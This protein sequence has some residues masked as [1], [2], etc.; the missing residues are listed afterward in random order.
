MLDREHWLSAGT[1]FEMGVLVE[2]RRIF[3]PITLDK[4]DNVGVYAPKDKLRMSGLVW[5]EAQAA[6]AQKAY[7]IHQSSGAGHVIA[8]AEEPN[9]RAYTEGT[10]LLFANAVLLGPAF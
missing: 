1:D 2:S 10:M 3:T 9:Y 5:D 6:L 4:G 7:L 8:F